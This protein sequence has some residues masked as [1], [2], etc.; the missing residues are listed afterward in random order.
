MISHAE[1]GVRH[2]TIWNM[3]NDFN[4]FKNRPEQCKEKLESSCF[5]VN[6][7]GGLVTKWQLGI[8]PKGKVEAH[9][10]YVGLYLYNKSQFKVTGE[11]KLDSGSIRSSPRYDL[12]TPYRL[13]IRNSARLF[14]HVHFNMG[15]LHLVL[16]ALY[17]CTLNAGILIMMQ[18]VRLM[19]FSLNMVD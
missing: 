10:D 2:T 3:A 8:Y 16:P 4:D 1:P 9:E 18:Q 11:Y 12:S 13:T 15:D 14:H 6:G 7:P 17:L 5:K 19:M